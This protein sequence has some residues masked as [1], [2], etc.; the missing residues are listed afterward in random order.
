MRTAIASGSKEGVKSIPDDL[1][2]F[3]PG[4]DAPLEQRM[5]WF[6]KAV[7]IANTRKPGAIP[8]SPMTPNPDL[9]TRAKVLEDEKD[10]LRRHHGVRPIR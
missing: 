4:V 3:D 2:A 1:K 5:A 6:E 8:R 9:T 10:R 7:E